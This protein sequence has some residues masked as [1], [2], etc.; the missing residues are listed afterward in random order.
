MAGIGARQR[1]S[2]TSAE[3][4]SFV[5]CKEQTEQLPLA[6]RETLIEASCPNWELSWR[7]IWTDVPGFKFELLIL[8]TRTKMHWKIFVHVSCCWSTVNFV[9]RF[10]HSLFL[11]LAF[12]WHSFDSWAAF[13]YKY[14]DW[15]NIACEE[16]KQT[17]RRKKYVY[18]NFGCIQA[19][20][21]GN[22]SSQV[23]L[24]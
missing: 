20:L 6:M 11:F 9:V 5:K 3:T 1:P 7:K 4:L 23:A 15:N 12:A 8:V 14:I 24:E 22:F 13:G 17:K 16:K 21:L 10:V 19:K 2:L 18:L